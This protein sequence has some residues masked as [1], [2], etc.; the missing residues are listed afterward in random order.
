MGVYHNFGNTSES[1]KTNTNTGLKQFLST[2]AADPSE[3][4]S[5]ESIDFL[6]HE[7]GS[8]LCSF[9]LR[10]EEVDV[11]ISLSAAGI[12]SLIAIEIRNWWRSNLGFDITV[13]EILNAGTIQHLGELAAQGLRTKFSGA[14]G[15]SERS[16]GSI[17]VSNGNAVGV[18]VEHDSEIRE[19]GDTY[20]V[21]K[22]P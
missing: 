13:L 7:I 9:L 16:E 8:Q 2:C 5:V 3:L 18:G 4:D 17:G 19:T 21:M 15:P 14:A 10:S 22:A 6:A 20:F 11:T 1:I 12:D